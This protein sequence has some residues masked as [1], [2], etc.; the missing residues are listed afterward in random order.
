MHF[1]TEAHQLGLPAWGQLELNDPTSL[2]DGEGEKVS[3]IV[4]LLAKLW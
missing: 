4:G 2:L 3:E 1:I